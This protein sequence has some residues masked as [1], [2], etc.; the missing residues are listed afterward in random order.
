[1]IHNI[2]IVEDDATISRLLKQHLG[3][4]GYQVTEIEDFS[5]VA[6]EARNI[7]PDLII[8]DIMLPYQNGFYWTQ[9]IRQF[10]KVPILFLS[11]ADDSMSIV[12][13]LN[14]GGDDFVAKPLDLAVFT[15]KVQALLR[16]SYEFQANKVMTTYYT[17]GNLRYVPNE[18]QIMLENQQTIHLTPT[19]NKLLMILFRHL[20]EVVPK[21]HIL[22]YLWRDDCYIDQNTLAVN[23]N[24]LRKKIVET[25]LK[26]KIAT[27]KAKGYLLE[28]EGHASE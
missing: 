25:P 7:Q 14:N 5:Q 19:E 15:A 21:E 28:K 13:A 23:M 10:S 9:Q 4:W 2:L 16:R 18:S 27:V 22:E 24:R 17:Y 1:M 6:E 20:G 26:D 3:Q 8:M 12:T 11:S